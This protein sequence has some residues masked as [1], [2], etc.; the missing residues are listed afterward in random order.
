MHRHSGSRPWH[1]TQR[2]TNG[3]A[4]LMPGRVP[5]CCPWGISSGGPGAGILD[6]GTAVFTGWATLKSGGGILHWLQGD[7]RQETETREAGWGKTTAGETRRLK[8]RWRFDRTFDWFRGALQKYH[9]DVHSNALEWQ[10][11]KCR[12]FSGNR[13]PPL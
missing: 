2:W 6:P 7:S 3:G 10:D 11:K 4:P 5:H 8:K 13:L 12:R 1:H 9:G